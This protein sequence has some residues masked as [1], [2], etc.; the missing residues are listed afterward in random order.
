MMDDSRNMIRS[1]D[2]LQE[3]KLELGLG[4]PD[5]VSSVLLPGDSFR[6]LLIYTISAAS[7]EVIVSIAPA[8]SLNHHKGHLVCHVRLLKRQERHLRPFDSILRIGIA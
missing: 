8:L 2:T 5:I 7:F 3:P 4:I 6:Y 1:Y